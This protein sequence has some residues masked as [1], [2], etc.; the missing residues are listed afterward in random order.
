M[1]PEK[2]ANI[3]LLPTYE[4]QR[5]GGFIVFILFIILTVSALG[6]VTFDYF[7]S[8]NTLEKLRIEEAALKIEV[9]AINAQLIALQNENRVD[10][11]KDSVL[12]A[13]NLTYPTSTFIKE[14]VD[15][16]PE[17]G[18]LTNYSYSALAVSI[19]NE[20]ESLDKIAD[21]TK[22]LET[23]K[24]ITDAKVNNITE[25]DYRVGIENEQDVYFELTPRY[26]A[27]FSLKMNRRAL[28]EGDEQDE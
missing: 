3:N 12:F 15:L 19:A 23:S 10:S 20:F 18:H 4:K 11:I 25:S 24:Y 28:V 16:L 17:N 27:N 9:D 21:Y 8:K 6:Y 7:S 14:V 22:S 26:Q 2:L 13:E 1:V 5:S